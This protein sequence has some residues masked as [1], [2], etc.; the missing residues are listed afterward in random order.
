MQVCF[1]AT[2][3]HA[4]TGSR[5]AR[6]RDG[7][8]IEESDN[9]VATVRKSLIYTDVCPKPRSRA[10]YTRRIARAAAKPRRLCDLPQRRARRRMKM[11]QTCILSVT[12]LFFVACLKSWASASPVS[13]ST[14]KTAAVP[15]SLDPTVASRVLSLYSI[16]ESWPGRSLGNHR[17]RLRLE[18]AAIHSS[19]DFSGLA[20]ASIEWRLPGLPM[21]ERAAAGAL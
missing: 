3:Y 16:A 11:A 5:Q 18:P 4:Q 10:E 21:E 7:T 1:A 2:M 19:G 8:I 17:A 12:M 6:P 13:S 9:R 15:M 14:P 20:Y